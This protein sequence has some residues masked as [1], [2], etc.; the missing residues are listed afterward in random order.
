MKYGK[1]PLMTF[2]ALLAASLVLT[3]LTD[4]SD[5]IHASRIGERFE[6]DGTILL[7]GQGS[8]TLFIL[9]R[10][11]QCMTFRDVTPRRLSTRLATG[12]AIHASG[13]VAINENGR[14]APNCDVLTVRDA[15]VAR[16]PLEVSARDF[17]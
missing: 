15:A 2:S 17:T 6:L 14:P 10:Q 1:I 5:A 13:V 8:N 16:P 12:N 9:A 4:V 11:N 7:P 3:N